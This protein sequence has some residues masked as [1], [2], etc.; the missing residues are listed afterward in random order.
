MQFSLEGTTFVLVAGFNLLPSRSVSIELVVGV[1]GGDELTNSH[2]YIPTYD[3]P[4]NRGPRDF[5]F[6]REVDNDFTLK[7]LNLFTL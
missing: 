7:I 6:R 5:Y 1:S 4:L 2:V 3:P